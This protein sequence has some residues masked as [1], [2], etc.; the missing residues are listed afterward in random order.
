MS[1]GINRIP[2][3][4][5]AGYGVR[6]AGGIDRDKNEPGGGKVEDRLD[7]HPDQSRPQEEQKKEDISLSIGT[8]RIVAQGNLDPSIE[9]ALT[10]YAPLGELRDA[11]RLCDILDKAGVEFITWPPH[12]TL[13]QA[14]DEAVAA[15]S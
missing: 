10:S 7:I 11:D 12:L 13:R 15:V 9:A 8:L 5:P 4:R 6:A 3:I 2:P 14:L 1:D